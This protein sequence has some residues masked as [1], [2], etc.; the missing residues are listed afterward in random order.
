[1]GRIPALI[2]EGGGFEFSRSTDPTTDDTVTVK[3]G[4]TWYVTGSD[5]SHNFDQGDVAVYDG[6]TWREYTVSSASELADYPFGESDLSFSPAKRPPIFGDGSDGQIIDDTNTSRSG[7]L[8]TES[9]KLPEGS[10]L[11]LDGPV[12]FI[13][14][15]SKITING[16]IDGV[17]ACQ[18]NGTGGAGT[19]TPDTSGQSPSGSP[20][21]AGGPGLLR[22]LEGSPG[23][24]Q[25]GGPGGNATG[26]GAGGA[27][28]GASDS[29]GDAAGGD[30]GAGGGKIDAGITD[31]MLKN[32]F[33][34]AYGELSRLKDAGAGGGGGGGGGSSDHYASS[35]TS[36]PSGGDGGAGAGALVLIAPE[37]E[38][39]GTIDLSGEDGED[40]T[41][42]NS[43]DGSAG[44]SGGGGGGAGGAAVLAGGQ[45]TDSGTYYFDGGNP[46]QGGNGNGGYDGGDGAPGASGPGKVVLTT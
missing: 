26:Y 23:T 12:L 18:N 24:G 35:T 42:G 20:G 41:D 22:Q 38:V 1:M 43:S 3:E 10:T 40:G 29:N 13:K 31:R 44:A 19:S 36:A 30:G 17:G 28:G 33:S 9:Y 32:L 2:P 39:N 25:T 15:Q 16:T 21:T 45:V 4:N 6:S 37:I 5:A 7:T 46:G 8:H 27:G 14:A 11:T 34:A